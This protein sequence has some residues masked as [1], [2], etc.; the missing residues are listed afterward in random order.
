MCEE[1]FVLRKEVIGR[2]LGRIGRLLDFEED[3]DT[4]TSRPGE[5]H[6]LDTL[7]KGRPIMQATNRSRQPRAPGVLPAPMDQTAVEVAAVEPELL[8]IHST[9]HRCPSPRPDLVFLRQDSLLDLHHLPDHRRLQELLPLQPIINHPRQVCAI[10]FI[11]S[12]VLIINR[13]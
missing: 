2:F 9:P 12:L 4:E 8:F 3:V 13:L 1:Q 5:A 7:S 11:C 10:R 6:P